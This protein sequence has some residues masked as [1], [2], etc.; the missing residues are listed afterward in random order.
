MTLFRHP[1]LKLAYAH[2]AAGGQVVYLRKKREG[3]LQDGWLIDNDVQ[4][5]IGTARRL[6]VRRI[7]VMRA[8]REG[9]CVELPPTQLARA[10]SECTTPEMNF[11]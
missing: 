1:D 10:V 8:N 5:L 3:E 9:Q 2:V 11:V 7:R 4:R 6:G